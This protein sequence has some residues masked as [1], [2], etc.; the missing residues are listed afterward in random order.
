MLT[1][2]DIDPVEINEFVAT[3]EFGMMCFILETLVLF[4]TEAAD[5]DSRKDFHSVVSTLT[6]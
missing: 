3:N 1:I 4:H 6:R 5:I 2:P